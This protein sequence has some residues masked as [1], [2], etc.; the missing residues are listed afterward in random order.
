MKKITIILLTSLA[1]TACVSNKTK[2]TNTNVTILSIKKPN[3]A[4]SYNNGQVAGLGTQIGNGLGGVAVATVV[5]I[6]SIFVN[7][8]TAKTEGI[9][10][11]TVGKVQNSDRFIGRYKITPFIDSLHV[12]DVA[13]STIDENGDLTLVQAE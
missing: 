7:E 2:L 11:I 13:K 8:A 9:A 10:E 6:A 12:G 5:S 3:D 4:S 1:L